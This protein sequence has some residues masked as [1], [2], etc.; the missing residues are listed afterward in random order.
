MPSVCQL[1]RPDSTL[2][3]LQHCQRVPCR[4]SLPALRRAHT[5][6]LTAAVN[7]SA[8]QLVSDKTFKCT[9]CGKCCTG[10]GEVWVNEEECSNIA[11]HFKLDSE[12]FKRTYCKSYD[13]IIGWR[14]LQYKPGPEKVRSQCDHNAHVASHACWQQS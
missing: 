6:V 14:A 12:T 3:R 13:S 8:I 2:V 5:Q 11:E 7:N 10:A 4:Q 9:E 1:A